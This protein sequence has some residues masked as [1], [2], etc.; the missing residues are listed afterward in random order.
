VAA[1]GWPARLRHEDVEVRPLRVRDTAAW[2]ELRLAN[3]DWLAPWEGSPAAQ[4]PPT[5]PWSERSSATVYATM[6]R[7]LRAEARAGRA[8]PFGIALGG[9]LV[10]QVTV[11]TIVRG[12]YDGCHVGYWVDRRVAG[13]GVMPTAL[14]LVVDHC[15]GDVGLHR[16]EANVRPENAASRRVV[17]KLGFR[18]EG[19]HRRYLF[20]DGAWRDHVSYAVLAEDGPVLAR[21]LSSR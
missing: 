5:A 15:F 12:A 11:S 2:V 21:Y 8:L 6:L 14:A 17:E 19:R 3:E 16:V 20:I 10:G 4:G 13:R 9:R 7:R 18:E 1:P